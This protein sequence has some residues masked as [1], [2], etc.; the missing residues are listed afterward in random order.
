VEIQFPLNEGE[1]IFLLIKEK[2]KEQTDTQFYGYHTEH[3]KLCICCTTALTKAL[4]VLI[5]VGS[6][7]I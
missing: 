7:Q 6:N 3:L 5:S 1:I 4:L 2:V